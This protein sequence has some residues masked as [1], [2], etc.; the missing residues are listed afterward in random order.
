MNRIFDLNDIV[1]RGRFQGNLGV[2]VNSAVYYG[3]G[4]IPAETSGNSFSLIMFNS[5]RIEQDW[6]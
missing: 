5:E 2:S 4:N 3:I 1:D 6:V